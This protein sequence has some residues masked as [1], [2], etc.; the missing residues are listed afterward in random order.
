MNS[1]WCHRGFVLQRH[2]L[3]FVARKF[4]VVGNFTYLCLSFTDWEAVSHVPLEQV[5]LPGLFQ[6]IKITQHHGCLF[7]DCHY[8]E[9]A[10]S[11]AFSKALRKGQREPSSLYWT[12]N[13]FDKADLGFSLGRQNN[14]KWRFQFLGTWHFT[15]KR[16]E[17]ST[18]RLLY[19]CSVVPLRSPV[20]PL[21]T[22]AWLASCWLHPHCM[23][24]LCWHCPI[25]ALR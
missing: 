24:A 13:R 23:I 10:P 17:L 12:R 16:M 18:P 14:K 8:G 21:F 4:W 3:E 19:A 22:I 11:K 15:P 2:H 20:F 9:P 1:V 5:E 7:P 6:G 25:S